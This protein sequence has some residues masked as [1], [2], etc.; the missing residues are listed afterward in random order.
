MSGAELMLLYVMV[1]L[2]GFVIGFSLARFR[3]KR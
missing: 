2:S 1:G 3:R